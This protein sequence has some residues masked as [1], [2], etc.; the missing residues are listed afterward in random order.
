MPLPLSA[1]QQLALA[2]FGTDVTLQVIH[3]VY[4]PATQQVTQ[5]TDE[6]TLTAIVGPDELQTSPDTGGQLQVQRRTF[7]I[8]QTAWP[9]INSDSIRRLGF[10]GAV[11]EVI[12]CSVCHTAGWLAINTRRWS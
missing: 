9:E 4:D 7:L 2:D 3:Q 5:T 8:A 1:E 10:D 6:T 11:Y 12:G